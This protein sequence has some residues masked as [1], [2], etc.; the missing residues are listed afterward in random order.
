[1]AKLPPILHSAAK[2]RRI[3]E[4][5]FRGV[6]ST[7]LRNRIRP[8]WRAAARD[9]RRW[10]LH[11][12]IPA[13][14]TEKLGHK[15]PHRVAPQQ[16][17]PIRRFRGEQLEKQRFLLDSRGS[18]SAE[19]SVFEP[20]P[21]FYDQRNVETRPLAKSFAKKRSITWKLLPQSLRRD[22]IPSNFANAW[23][24]EG[25]SPAG[26]SSWVWEGGG[27]GDWREW[28]EWKEMTRTLAGSKP[29]NFQ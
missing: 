10:S 3:L 12:T 13:G 2:S 8:P 24:M 25:E 6:S 4:F 11:S 26:K 28:R 22:K 23:V 19:E 9:C 17:K 29:R 18:R 14:I 1:M 27:S 16:T 7:G 5:G 20:D 21:R 15:N